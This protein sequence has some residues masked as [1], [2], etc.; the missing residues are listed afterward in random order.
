L[1]FGAPGG[2]VA[3]EAASIALY[4]KRCGLETHEAT[5]I[6]ARRKQLVM[7]A[8]AAYLALGHLLEVRGDR[9]AGAG[10]VRRM[11]TKPDV[12]ERPLQDD[13]WWLYPYGQFYQ[14]ERRIGELRA[15]LGRAR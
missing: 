6:A 15:I 10:T 11:I 3:S 9:E 1:H 12:A 8:H 5:V 4:A 14:V 13:P 2:V 7:R